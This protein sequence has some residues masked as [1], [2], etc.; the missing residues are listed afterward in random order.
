MAVLPIPIEM[1]KRFSIEDYYRMRDHGLLSRHTEL[2]DGVLVDRMTVSPK[3]T[4]IVSYLMNLL[5]EI[6]PKDLI[7]SKENPITIGNSEPEPD[8]SIVTGSLNDYKETHPT[9]AEWVIEVAIS[10]LSLDL[11]KR[12]IYAEAKIPH[13]W[14]IDPEN[15]KILVFTEP[16]GEQYSSETIYGMQDEIPVPLIKDKSLNFKWI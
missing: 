1:V 11:S 5:R 2:L 6:L 13:Y 3:H 8:I 7:F 14:T 15:N 9:T 16:K 4:Y 10:S 12:K